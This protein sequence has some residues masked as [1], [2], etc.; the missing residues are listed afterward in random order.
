M[1]LF[2]NNKKCLKKKD[3]FAFIIMCVHI[4]TYV[5]NLLPKCLA[6]YAVFLLCLMDPVRH[7]DHLVG[8]RENCLLCFSLLSNMCTVCLLTLPLGAECWLDIVV[9]TLSGIFCTITF[10]YFCIGFQF[11]KLHI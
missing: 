5:Y 7:C 10:I 2:P 6:L 11:Y 1:T 4:S 9:V 3:I 8:G